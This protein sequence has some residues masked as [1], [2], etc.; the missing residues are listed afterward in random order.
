M[1]G[2]KP[3]ALSHNETEIMRGCF[4]LLLLH[5]FATYGSAIGRE[6]QLVVGPACTPGRCALCGPTLVADGFNRTRL[7]GI[8]GIL[9]LPSPNSLPP[10]PCPT[11]LHCKRPSRKNRNK[12]ICCLLVKI[13]GRYKCP[14]GKVQK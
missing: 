11:L 3:P 12:M 4:I 8:T 7:S 5:T 1:G 9:D 2:V 13:R 10:S 6:D 14:K